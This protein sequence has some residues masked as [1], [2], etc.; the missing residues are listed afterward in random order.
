MS[1]YFPVSQEQGIFHE[2][3]CDWNPSELQL[4]SRKE[5]PLLRKM[6][7]VLC[8]SRNH[9]AGGG[10][11]GADPITRAA[12]FPL[13]LKRALLWADPRDTFWERA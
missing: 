11:G 5:R 8:D 9:L 12:S 13:T 7:F 10:G 2:W 6:L 3:L 4:P 1:R